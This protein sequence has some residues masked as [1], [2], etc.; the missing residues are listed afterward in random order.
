MPKSCFGQLLTTHTVLTFLTL[1]SRVFAAMGVEQW[2]LWELKSILQKLPVDRGMLKL[3][4][5]P[6]Y[7]AAQRGMISMTYKH[8]IF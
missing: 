4:S 6:W 5:V 3:V 2:E 1:Q 7:I 8:A